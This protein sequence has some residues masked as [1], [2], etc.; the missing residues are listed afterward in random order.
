MKAELKTVGFWLSMSTAVIGVIAMAVGLT[1]EQ[2][3]ALVTAIGALLAA[4]AQLG[5]LTSEAK[6]R[7]AKIAGYLTL[8]PLPGMVCTA[9]TPDVM[10]LIKD[11]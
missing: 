5:F 1:S 10:Q 6:V 11:A 9:S 2:Q 3:N 4:G 7:C 8:Q